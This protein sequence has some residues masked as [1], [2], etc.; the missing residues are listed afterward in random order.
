MAFKKTPS[1]LWRGRTG[2]WFFKLG[3][4]EELRK[5][6][7]DPLTDKPRTHI[8][9]SL[10]THSHQ[11]AEQR[12]LPLL[13]KYRAEFRVLSSG[14]VTKT[15]NPALALV[16]ALR[17]EMAALAK[18]DHWDDDRRE[19]QS[20]ALSDEID[21]VHREIEKTEGEEAAAIAARRML[22]PSKRTLNEAL[23]SLTS[24]STNKAQTVDTY[25]MAVR[26]LLGFLKVPDC[27]PDDVTEA[28]AYAYVEHLNNGPLSKSSKRTRLS[29]LGALWQHMKR[30]GWPVSPWKDQELTDPKRAP[31]PSNIPLEGDKQDSS[32]ADQSGD[33]EEN[34]DV[35]PF[36]EAEAIGVFTL[37]EPADKRKRKYT[38]ALFRELYAIGF[39][40]GM[41]L[42]EI[43][44]LRRTDVEVLDKQWR[45]ITI[46]KGIAK[47]DAGARKIPVC[48]PVVIAIL[49]SRIE[50]QKDPKGQLFT[51]CTPGG[52][53]NKASWK[54]GSAMS[55]ERI[56]KMGFKPR[57]VDFH[58]TRRNFATLLEEQPNGD[59]VAQQR[60]IGHDIGTL[61]HRVYSGGSGVEK[62]KSV[63]AGLKYPPKLEEAFR[64]ATPG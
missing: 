64:L 46:P 10:H 13:L 27:F 59:M 61:M 42:N 26:E 16:P 21:R 40:T 24:T 63:V 48:H 52:K 56:Q 18:A 39:T 47:T 31:K 37:P 4:P 36:T 44:S 30:R 58:S 20:L 57:E 53:D 38:R 62:L 55:N 11:E 43:A 41:R 45:V 8:V 54:V 1:Y 14:V 6:Y 7:R 50:K 22:Y 35:R 2:A 33:D 19:A 23:A 49:D 5:H 12:K 28:K 17:D 25:R 34:E 9:E 32:A 29:G 15:I 3:I 51:E 60:Y